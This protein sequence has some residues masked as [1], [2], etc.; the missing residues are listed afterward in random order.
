[1]ENPW[2]ATARSG[3]RIIRLLLDGPN[4]T[5]KEIQAAL[6]SIKQGGLFGYRFQYPPMAVGS[7][8]DLLA[9]SPCGLPFAG[10]ARRPTVLPDVLLGYLTA[11]DTKHPDLDRPI[12]LWPRLYQRSAHLAAIEL[13][14]DKKHEHKTI[15]RALN[16]L[17]AQELLGKEKLPRSFARQIL[18]LPENK[19]LDEWLE[20]LPEIAGNNERGSVACQSIAEI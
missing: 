3:L 15:T 1:M 2:P 9:P 12:E 17:A 20:S 6:E 13:F 10:Y 8:P 18:M 7:S 19:T 14:K 16:L 5:R 11:Y 4:A